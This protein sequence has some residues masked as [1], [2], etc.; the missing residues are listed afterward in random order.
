MVVYQ[1]TLSV[2]D[3]ER[4]REVLARL[5][6]MPTAWVCVSGGPVSRRLL[7]GDTFLYVVIASDDAA[8]LAWL[9][10]S[11]RSG[12][13]QAA[14]NAQIQASGL[15]SCSVDETSVNVVAPLA[16]STAGAPEIGRA[17]V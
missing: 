10:D 11:V 7:A 9:A 2:P 5:L 8:A 15:A 13:F 3:A 14:L 12:E 6:G 4:Y 17:H 16:T 1:R